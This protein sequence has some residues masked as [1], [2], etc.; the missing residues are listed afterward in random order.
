MRCQKSSREKLMGC[1]K[2]KEIWN[3]HGE[4][5]CEQLPRS[6]RRDA[7]KTLPKNADCYYVP[8]FTVVK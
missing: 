1:S 8:R 4:V 3:E 2:Q 5:N 6:L 7:S